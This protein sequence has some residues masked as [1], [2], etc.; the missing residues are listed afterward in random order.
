MERWLV[1]QASALAHSEQGKNKKCLL[2]F[3]ECGIIYVSFFDV[4]G[5]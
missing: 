4:L 2:F 5:W 1:P 3:N